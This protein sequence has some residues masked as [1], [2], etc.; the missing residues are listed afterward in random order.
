METT[1]SDERTL[2]ISEV[3]YNYFKSIHEEEKLDPNRLEEFKK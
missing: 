1:F 3:I 2:M